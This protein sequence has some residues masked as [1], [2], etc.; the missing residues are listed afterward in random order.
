[1]IVWLFDID[2]TLIESGRAG[3]RAT[4]EAMRTEF[5]LDPINGD[6]PF[7]GR[8]DRAIIFD[9]FRL[10]NIQPSEANWQRFRR[11]YLPELSRQ[12][13]IRDGQ[14][15]PGARE[16]VRTIETTAD[17][18]LGLLTGNIRAGAETK[19]AFFQLWKH[20]SFGGFGDVHLS[21]NDVAND[22]L[23]ASADTLQTTI[24]PSDVW[25]VGDT[26]NDI[27][28]AR[29]IGANVLAV[30]T[31]GSTHEQLQEAEPDLLVEDLTDWPRI[32]ASV[33]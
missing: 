17:Q 2:G 12:L 13:P 31:G 7:A 14:V 33:A 11:R 5:G 21:R 22:A 30:S 1:M 3:S 20:F 27:A 10:H 25:V 26:V 19:L 9:L 18:H 8:T 15:L 28:C 16:M 23:N 4:V 24:D 32:L 6:V 29:S